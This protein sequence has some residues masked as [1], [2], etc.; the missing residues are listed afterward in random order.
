MTRSRRE[1][2]TGAMAL[3]GGL[4]MPRRLLASPSSVSERQFLFIFCPGGWDQSMIFAPPFNSDIVEAEDDI[5]LAE[6]NG[7]TF[8]SSPSRP[9]VS[10][11]FSDWGSQ[12]CLI[13]GFESRSVAH[14]V[15]LRLAMTGTTQPD[16]DDWPALIASQAASGPLMPLVHLSGPSYTFDHGEAVVRVGSAGQLPKL[17]DGTALEFS[18]MEV[19]LP[20]D[21]VQLLEDQAVYAQAEIRAA[22]AARGRAELILSGALD[23]ELRLGELQELSDSLVLG[24]GETLVERAQILI[25]CFSSGVAR[26]G[27]VAYDGIMELGW[28]TH[29]ANHVQSQH[30]EGLFEGLGEIMSSLQSTEDSNGNPLIE[31]VTV[32]VLSEMGRYPKYNTRGGREHW[33]FTSA[34]LMGSGVRGG[35]VIGGFDEYAAGQPTDLETGQVDD[36]GQYL[37]TGNVGATLLSLADMDPAEFIPNSDPILA[38]LEDS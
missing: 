3:C 5:S 22:A 35:Q 12:T 15:C 1:F 9:S 33:T 4:W 13:N 23:A 19:A 34:M 30:F 17:L 25:D 26:C 8:V 16:G 28:D 20:G 21:A 18:D 36:A 6:L 14:D 10:S 29:A 11:F 2:M 38:A 32:V 7:I 27:M 37:V 31:N 24:S